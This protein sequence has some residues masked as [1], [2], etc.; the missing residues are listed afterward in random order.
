MLELAMTAFTSDLPPTLSFELLNNG[1]NFHL[2]FLA[3]L[4]LFEYQCLQRIFVVKLAKSPLSTKSITF[5][6][7]GAAKPRPVSEA[8]ELERL[9]CGDVDNF[10]C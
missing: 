9:V 2:A 3:R 8:N 6:L 4:W 1:F 10:D 7:S 5:E